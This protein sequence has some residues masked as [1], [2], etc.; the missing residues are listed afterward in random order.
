MEGAYTGPEFSNIEIRKALE[1]SNVG[2]EECSD[3]EVTKRA[4]QDIADGLVVGGF[5]VGWNLVR[6][7]LGIDR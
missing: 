7:R 5:K 2:F 1:S 4:A 3:E 6:G